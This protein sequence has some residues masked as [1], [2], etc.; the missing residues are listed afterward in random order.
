MLE[1][2]KELFENLNKEAV[3]KVGQKRKNLI[4]EEHVKEWGG[5]SLDSI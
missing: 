4:E 2:E 5:A 3:P 1:Q